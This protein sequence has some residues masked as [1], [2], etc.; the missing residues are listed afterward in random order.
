MQTLGFTEEKQGSKDTISPFF[1][2]NT[3]FAI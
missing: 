2:D 1:N 3:T